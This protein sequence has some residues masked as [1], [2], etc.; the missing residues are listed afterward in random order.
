MQMYVMK[1]NIVNHIPSDITDGYLVSEKQK[2][3]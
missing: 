3:G 2:D 1:R